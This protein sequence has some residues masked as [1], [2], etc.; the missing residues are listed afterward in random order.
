MTEHLT[1]RQLAN[2][3]KR[4]AAETAERIARGREAFERDPEF[5]RKWYAIC[6]RLN[7]EAYGIENLDKDTRETLVGVLGKLGSDNDNERLEAAR[8]AERLRVKLGLLWN[9]LVI[10]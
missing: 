7:R 5:Q 9:D 2:K 8:Q 10:S 1:P 3:A 6:D 4:E